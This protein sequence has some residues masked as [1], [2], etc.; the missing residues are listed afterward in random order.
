VSIGHGVVLLHLVV[1]GLV[2]VV[3]C[4]PFCCTQ[5]FQ[6]FSPLRNK[7]LQ[8]M[9]TI[10]LEMHDWL[11]YFMFFLMLTLFCAIIYIRIKYPFWSFIN[12]NHSYDWFLRQ[13]GHLISRIPSRNKFVVRNQ[14]I[15][16]EP[17]F[18]DKCAILLQKYYIPS[19]KILYECEAKHIEAR[20]TGHSAQMSFYIDKSNTEP[21]GVMTSYL[22]NVRDDMFPSLITTNYISYIVSSDSSTTQKLIATH[23]YNVHDKTPDKSTFILKKDVGRC[24]GLR[25]L[26][27][28]STS[29]FYVDSNHKPKLAK[30]TTLVQIYKDNWHMVLD[31][32]D[33]VRGFVL[34]LDIGAIQAR[35]KAGILFIYALMRRGKIAAMYFIEDAH[36]LYEYVDDHGGKTLRL[37]LTIIMDTDLALIYG[38]FVGALAKISKQNA[39]YK[40]LLVD[41]VGDN[42]K[43]IAYL[44]RD[45]RIIHITTTSGAYY[46]VNWAY[47]HVWESNEVFILV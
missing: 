16:D 22:V 32:I 5:R 21:T 14:V 8:E 27:I 13:P 38:G 7:T 11:L 4:L 18:F 15:T 40:M 17:K 39:D 36:M 33:S 46:L 19:D 6:F 12:A 29:L 35:V 28:F 37:V 2:L 23:I 20:I 26:T 47:R 34:T 24:G 31:A 41:S 45:S 25:P 1:T 3:L 43:I 9:F 44:E 10:I 42:Q 30:D